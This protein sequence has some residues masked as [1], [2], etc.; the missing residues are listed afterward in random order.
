MVS[1]LDKQTKFLKWISKTALGSGRS[2]KAVLWGLIY[3]KFA[4]GRKSAIPNL[5]I[6]PSLNYNS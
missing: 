5:I 1:F 6:S 4:L 2:I 3:T